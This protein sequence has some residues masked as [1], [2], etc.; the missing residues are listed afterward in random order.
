MCFSIIC[1]SHDLYYCCYEQ[2]DLCF[3]SQGTG[4]VRTAVGRGGQFCCISVP[5]LLKYLCAKNYENIMRFDRVIAK[6]IRVQFFAWQ[7]RMS[8]TKAIS[9]LVNQIL[10]RI[11]LQTDVYRPRKR[12]RLLQTLLGEIKPITRVERLLFVK[13]LRLH[14]V[15]SSQTRRGKRFSILLLFVVQMW[16]STNDD[17][18]VINCLVITWKTIVNATSAQQQR[19]T[20]NHSHHVSVFT[21][22]YV[23]THI[24]SSSRCPG[25]RIMTTLSIHAEEQRRCA[26]A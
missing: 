7:C 1:N 18:A 26:T 23:H 19:G 6:I 3:V 4:R 22:L 14:V 12:L 11:L 16:Q 20:I 2:I 15:I 10:R 13:P 9:F 17:E 24:G 25:S 5:N 8:H 21:H